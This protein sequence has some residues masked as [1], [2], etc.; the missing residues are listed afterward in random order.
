MKNFVHLLTEN[1]KK[2]I[3][4]FII[5]NILLVF[6]ETFSIALIPLMIDFAI[7]SNPILPQYFTFLK[8]FLNDF[9]KKNILLYGS[10]FL[11]VLFMLKNIYVI[12]LVAFQANLFRN[13]SRQI[14]RKFF[15]LYLDA[16]FE[17]INN[18]NSSQILRNTDDEASNYVN[19]FFLL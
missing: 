12:F 6:V 8:S 9:D 13:F 14:K 15:K 16:P 2:S 18:Y 17:I 5:L 10:L 11:I 4:L 3:I 1:N 19:N 7:S